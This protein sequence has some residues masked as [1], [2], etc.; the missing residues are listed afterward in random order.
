MDLPLLKM[1]DEIFLSAILR[2]AEILRF[3]QRESEFQIWEKTSDSKLELV[4]SLPS[5]VARSIISRIK[6]VAELQIDKHS[7]QEGIYSLNLQIDDSK[8]KKQLKVICLP[9]IPSGTEEVIIVFGK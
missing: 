1:I 7:F 2:N 4:L 5:N 9:T 8:R 3:I 6:I